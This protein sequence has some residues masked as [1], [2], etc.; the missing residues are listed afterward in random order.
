MNLILSSYEL[1]YLLIDTQV[2]MWNCI[3]PRRIG[4]QLHMSLF[5]QLFMRPKDWRDP[6][7]V[8]T[9][10]SSINSLHS[11]P[12]LRTLNAR[13][14]L[15]LFAP[16]RCTQQA[17]FPIIT[18]RFGRACAPFAFFFFHL[19]IFQC[20]ANSFLTEKRLLS[21]DFSFYSTRFL[22]HSFS[23]FFIRSPCLFTKTLLF[24]HI[25]IETGS[26][27]LH[28]CVCVLLVASLYPKS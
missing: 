5:R 10:T 11:D 22:F 17:T 2:P 16:T 25:S 13:P 14:H 12:A 20:Y 8:L 23:Y 24:K 26:L 3:S 7:P 15:S 9:V 18:A 27:N 21:T 6:N 1:R 28:E 4:N 19:S